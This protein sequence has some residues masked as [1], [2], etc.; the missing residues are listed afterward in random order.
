MT[1]LIAILIAIL[2]I[3]IL[4]G[5]TTFAFVFYVSYKTSNKQWDWEVLGPKE[6]LIMLA[7]I[8]FG[9]LFSVLAMRVINEDLR[10]ERY[11][12]NKVPL[13]KRLLV[14]KICQDE[15]HP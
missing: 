9:P 12:R 5:L 14:E 11:K 7:L 15:S 1:T 4:I 2:S 6:L 8:T 3:W 13:E 10:W